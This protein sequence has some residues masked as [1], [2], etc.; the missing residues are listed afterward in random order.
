MAY[1]RPALDLRRREGVSPDLIPGMRPAQRAAWNETPQF[2]G[3]PAQF[4]RVH[5]TM[6]EAS[7]RLVKG[8]EALLDE[9]EGSAQDLLGLT[10]MH[11]LGVELVAR[12]SHHHA[13]ED[14]TVL[15]RILAQCPDLS[16]GV[17]LLENDHEVLD[18]SLQSA[19]RSFEALDPRESRKTAIDQ[20]LQ[21][22][23]TLHRILF[24][25]TY[26]EE[27]LLIP[28]VLARDLHL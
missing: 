28:A 12:V 26:D 6:T 15:P 7:T 5:A 14:S 24:R 16:E 4:Q 18:A 2:L 20:A 27:D 23:R 1:D 11:H 8:L 9:P 10:G 21:E 13:Y 17:T 19:R 22:A 25:H 3:W